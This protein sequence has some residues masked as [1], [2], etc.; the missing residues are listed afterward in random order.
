MN[1]QPT[2]HQTRNKTFVGT[3]RNH[4]HHSAF[5][6]FTHSN[7][8]K[9]EL[10]KRH[11]HDRL[12]HFAEGILR[13]GKNIKTDR[14]CL[15][16]ETVWAADGESWVAP[17]FSPKRGRYIYCWPVERRC[18]PVNVPRKA[19]QQPIKISRKHC[20]RIEVL[21]LGG[22]ITADLAKSAR[23]AT[24]RQQWSTSLIC[25]SVWAS[26]PWI[27]ALSAIFSLVQEVTYLVSFLLLPW[28]RHAA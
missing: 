19:M 10:G 4:M 25:V 2:N 8:Q 22:A 14:L 3:E 11:D 20:C 12:S 27:S 23:G 24:R 1:A 18:Q 28:A 5:C 13:T 17:I 16:K 7:R 6:Q 9:P 26:P 15:E 21:R